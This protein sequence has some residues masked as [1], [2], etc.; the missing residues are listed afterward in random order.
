MQFKL[1]IIVVFLGL[2]ARANIEIG[3]HQGLDQ[4]GNVCSLTA[5]NQTFENNAP[6][7]LNERISISVGDDQFQVYHPRSIDAATSTVNFNHDRLESVLPYNAGAKALVIE[8]VHSAEFEGPTAF[9]WIMD[10]WKTGEKSKIICS[11][12]KFKQ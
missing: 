1:G 5:G 3:V 2:T 6:H 9:T 8:M 4:N 12:L 10:N 11:G 7:P